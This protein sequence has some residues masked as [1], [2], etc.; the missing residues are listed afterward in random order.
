MGQLELALR[1]D[2]TG[3]EVWRGP[4]PLHVTERLIAD[5]HLAGVLAD[6]LPND[7]EPIRLDAIAL[8]GGESDMRLDIEV[9]GGGRS[10][11]KTYAPQR[12]V[13]DDAEAI[14]ARLRVAK[15]ISAGVYRFTLCQDGPEA[16]GATLLRVRPLARRLP[17]FPALSVWTNGLTPAPRCDHPTILVPRRAAACLLAQARAAPEV[18][19]GALLVVVPFC[20]EETLPCRLGIRVVEVV[21]LSHG[22][23]GTEMRLRVT[24]EALAAVPIDEAAGRRR[25]GIAHS[26]PFGDKAAPFFLSAEDKA[27]ATGWFWHP[28]QIQIVVDPRFTEPQDAVAAFCWVDGGLVRVCVRFTTDH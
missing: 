13:L 11:R 23:V 12:A 18:E 6:V 2:E 26:H 5:T 19:V 14:V 1:E 21:P 27:M 7:G 20:F 22:T 28:Y 15:A 3:R 16:N 4:L 24:P 8:A 17:R 25:G 10:F 9:H